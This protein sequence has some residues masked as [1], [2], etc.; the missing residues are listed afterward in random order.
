MG[1]TVLIAKSRHW[2][3]VGRKTPGGPGLAGASAWA[4]SRP[5]A[6]TASTSNRAAPPAAPRMVS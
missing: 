2:A 1:S 4:V 6:A 3:S 5:N